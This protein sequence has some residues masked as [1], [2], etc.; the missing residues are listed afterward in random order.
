LKRVMGTKESDPLKLN[1]DR[2]TRSARRALRGRGA[3]RT[4]P[5]SGTPKVFE[6]WMKKDGAPG[7]GARPGEQF[8]ASSARLRALRVDLLRVKGVRVVDRFMESDPLNRSRCLTP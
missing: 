1:G 6:A 8:S 7:R 5:S 4:D 2:S 3:W